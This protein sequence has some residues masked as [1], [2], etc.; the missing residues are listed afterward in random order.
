MNITMSYTG[1]TTRGRQL[2]SE[3]DKLG[4][5]EVFYTPVL[6][7]KTQIVPN[8]LYPYLF[9][10]PMFNL[11]KLHTSLAIDGFR[12]LM[13]R[14][15]KLRGVSRNERYRVNEVID[16]W[17]AH[18]LQH[19][20]D[21]LL[22]E[23]QI[24]L[25]TIRR[26]KELGMMT[27]I[28]RTNSHIAHQ[29]EIWDDV[30]KKYNLDWSINSNRV[31]NKGIQEYEETDYIFT[32]ST[33]ARNSFLNKNFSPKKVIC[34]PPGLN[35]DNFRRVKKEDNIFR[36][37]YCGRLQYI[38]GTHHLLEAFHNL[39]L[40]NAELWLIGQLTDNIKLYL[41]K[42]GT[43][44][45]LFGQVRNDKLYQY[46]SQ[47][48]VFVFPSSDDGFGKV[49]IEAMACGLPIIAST[50]CGSLDLVRPNIDGYIIPIQDVNAIQE[51]IQFMYDNPHSAYVMGQNALARVHA[52][53]TLTHYAERM[54]KALHS[55]L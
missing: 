19:I 49:L 31:V 3:F 15:R 18:K 52:N 9:G 48:S 1:G 34:V 44:C 38:K 26:A 33:Y 5:L 45:K 54:I 11:K 39:N 6:S 17:V 28:D 7:R 24:G 55:V 20:S 53:F 13:W 30:K 8:W 40:K 14:T 36:V 2:A 35:L 50:N 21:V 46:F 43:N 47:G 37:I 10:P 23:G 29:T 41:R 16:R 25:H 32:L 22:V 42:Y 51:K 27:V 12:E 4:Y